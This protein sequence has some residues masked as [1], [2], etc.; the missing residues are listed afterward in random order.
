MVSG[1]SPETSSGGLSGQQPRPQGSGLVSEH[2]QASTQN[3]VPRTPHPFCGIAATLEAKI[4][5]H[6]TRTTGRPHVEQHVY[7]EGTYDRI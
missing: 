2:A 7:E 4:P 6:E 1:S 3:D 5:F